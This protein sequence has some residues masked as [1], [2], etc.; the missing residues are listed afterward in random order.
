MIGAIL[1]LL[2]A[3]LVGG[4][5]AAFALDCWRWITEGRFSP[6]PLGQLWYDLHPASL[7]L[8]QAAI[9]RY[10]WAALWDPGIVWVLTQPAAAV[11]AVLGVLFA[12]LGRR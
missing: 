10:V 6:A 11:L 3:I 8:S 4:A 5:L 1:R 7:G 2:G 9:Q 12:V